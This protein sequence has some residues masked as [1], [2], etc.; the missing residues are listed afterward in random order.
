MFFI[1]LVS[2][3]ELKVD[4][5]SGSCGSGCEM[6]WELDEGGTF[7]VE[8]SGSMKNFGNIYKVPWR[9]YV[10]KLKSVFV[11]SGVDHIGSV[12]FQNGGKIQNVTLPKTIVSINQFAFPK[13]NLADVYY[14]G[15]EEEWDAI[16]ISKIGNSGINKAKVHY[17]CKI[18]DSINVSAV[19]NNAFNKENVAVIEIDTINN[20]SKK[21]MSG[22][23]ELY[24]SIERKKYVGI[25]NAAKVIENK[26]HGITELDENNTP[27]VYG[28][29]DGDNDYEDI[30]DAVDGADLQAMKLAIM[31]K[32]LTGSTLIAA[33]VDGD[34]LLDGSDLQTMKLHIKNGR[35]FPILK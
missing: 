21:V 6:K 2:N 35:Q 11:Y 8:G 10:N 3:V 7:T 23:Y 1:F 5:S 9:N 27:F 17:N 31:G 28:N 14:E 4:A 19:Y 25:V 22:I 26:L 13:N 32:A 33:D 16:I 34:G 24:Y 30:A 18:I 20:N 12:A 15:T 29:V